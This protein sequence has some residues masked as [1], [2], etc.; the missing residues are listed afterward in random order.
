MT[1]HYDPP[2]FDAAMTRDHGLGET[3]T[4]PTGYYWVLPSSIGS[5]WTIMGHENGYW[6]QCGSAH[7]LRTNEMFERGTGIVGPIMGP[8]G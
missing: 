8:A 5:A 6:T 3:R 7:P 4:Y 1:A 2:A